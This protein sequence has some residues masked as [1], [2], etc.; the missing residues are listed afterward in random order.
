MKPTKEDIN[1]F[2]EKLGLEDE[3][4]KLAKVFCQNFTIEGEITEDLQEIL[5]RAPDSL[6]DI[7]WEEIKKDTLENFERR[8]KELILLSNIPKYL[9][10]QLIYMEPHKLRLLVQ[11]MNQRPIEIMQTTIVNEEF[12]PKGWVFTFIDN[13]NCTFVVPKQVRQ[14]VI[15]IEQEDI[16]LQMA[17]V[18]GIRC[19]MN[20]CLRLYGVFKKEMFINIYKELVFKGQNYET[21]NLEE[22]VKAILRVFEEENLIYRNGN[23]IV[24]CK[25][26]S[27]EQ[28][29]HIIK[30]Q[31]GK[32]FY[33]LD[34]EDIAT[35]GLGKWIDKTEGYTAVCSCLKKEIKDLEQAEEMLEEIA[36]KVVILD[37]GIPQI[38]NCLYQWNVA[39]DNPQSAR[40]MTKVLS[41]WL[42][43]IRRWSEC[44]YS[45][46]ARQLIND[47]NEYI[48]FES[49]NY[50]QS[51]KD[52]KIYPNDPCPCGSGKKYKKCCGKA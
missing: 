27:E 5:H 48:A 23:N 10:E 19:V 14:A 43:T 12:V 42:Y 45:K 39:F 37:W 17:F 52:I 9:E 38:M 35:Y 50:N 20:T 33:I 29:N 15:K 7:I 25:I 6:L 28:Y 47:Q 34:D 4:D 26:N 3:M 1:T 18:F 40:R 8:D 24:S 49:L 31:N 21:M 36:E 2:F 16:K 51:I 30:I 22:N 32:D 44:G 11:V 41:E 46:K 13:N